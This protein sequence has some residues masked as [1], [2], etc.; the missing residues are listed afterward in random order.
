MQTRPGGGA[1]LYWSGA[2]LLTVFGFLGQFSMGAPFFLTGV[3]MLAVG[4]WRHRPEILWSALVGVWAFVIG[5]ILVAPL[6]CTS[7]VDAVLQGQPQALSHTTCT[8]ALGI[9]YSG[10]GTYNPSLAPAFL[11]GLTIGV[12]GAFL[13]RRLLTRRV[14]PSDGR[15]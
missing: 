1:I 13:T 12:L 4:R 9:D 10:T 3:A 2:V 15:H 7:T 14:H 11:A 5:Y 8:N 6:G